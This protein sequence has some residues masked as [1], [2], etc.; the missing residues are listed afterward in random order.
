MGDI[1]ELLGDGR[2]FG[3][4]LTYATSAARGIA[5]AIGLAG[6]FVGDDSFCVVLGDNIL[7]G[8]GWRNAARLRRGAVG[9]R[10]ALVPR[11]GPAALR[12]GGARR[13][14]QGV[15]FEEKPA[16]PKS[17]LIPIGVYF[18]RPDAFDVIE[19]SRRRA[20]ASSR[21]PTCSTTTSRRRPVHPGLRRP[22]DRRRH[23]AVAP[24][25]GRAGRG[26][27]TRRA[28]LAAT[29]RPTRTTPR[30]RPHRPRRPPPGHRRRRLHRQPARP[31]DPRRRDGTRITVLDSCTYAGNRANLAVVEADPEQAARFAFVQGDIADPDVGRRR[32]SLRRTRSSTSPPSRTSTA[33][34]WTRRRS[35]APAYRRARAAGGGPRGGGRARRRPPA[36]PR[37]LQVSTDEVYG[38]IRPGAASRR[39]RA[40][41][42]PYAAAKAAGELLSAPPQRPSG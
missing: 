11:P 14:R 17:D 16:H 8:T 24:A 23:G 40:P 9:R 27:T 34:S 1:V 20:A 35:C 42:S 39:T 21:S 30:D 2:E 6:N 31:D 7:R 3:L 37:L 4:D 15:G 38:E 41:R 18:L 19:R 12:R 33:R 25:R 22:L 36:A 32:S 5:H 26:R 10:H 13:E 28:R 29:P